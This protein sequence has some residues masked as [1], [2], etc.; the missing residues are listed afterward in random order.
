MM[1]IYEILL[2]IAFIIVAVVLIAFFIYKTVKIKP[3]EKPT[4]DYSEIIKLFGK[5][6]ISNVERTE[7]RVRIEVKDINLVL[8]EQLKPYTNGVFTIGNKVVVT[9]KEQTEE[10]VKLLEGMIKWKKILL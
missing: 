10:I 6:N 2:M 9:F 4:K 5:D 1:Q 7:Q 8:L 3:Q